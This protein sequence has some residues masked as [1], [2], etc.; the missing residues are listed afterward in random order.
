MLKLSW[1]VP[2]PIP[3]FSD[4]GWRLASLRA[5]NRPFHDRNL[6]K[7][8]HPHPTDISG[9]AKAEISSQTAQTKLQCEVQLRQQVIVKNRRRRAKAEDADIEEQQK[10]KSLLQDTLSAQEHEQQ[11]AHRRHQLLFL[12]ADTKRRLVPPAQVIFL[13]R[14]D[15]ATGEQRRQAAHKRTQEVRSDE[16]ASIQYPAAN[17]RQEQTIVA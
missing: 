15:N 2:E 1:A 6:Q 16:G 9:Q 13:Q 5:G 10:V 14:E 3:D 4:V 8:R 17:N 7:P 12:A 11:L